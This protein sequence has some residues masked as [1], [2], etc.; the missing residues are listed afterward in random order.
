MIRSRPWPVI[1]VCL[2]FAVA[3]GVG[4]IYHFG[5]LFEPG[6]GLYEVILVEVLRLLAI[7]CAILLW[8]GI[9]WARW[10]AIAWI[11]YHVFIGAKHSTSELVTH[12][13]LLIGVAVLLYLPRSRVFF[14]NRPG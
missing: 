2:L 5:E 3:G 11:A 6:N 9:N 8:M 7:V 10:L 14:N 12:I 4:F 1:I 13:V